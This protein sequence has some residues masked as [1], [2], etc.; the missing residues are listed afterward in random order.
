[1]RRIV[2]ALT[3]LIA[4]GGVL[5]FAASDSN[6]TTCRVSAQDNPCLAQDATI[7]ALELE[8]LRAQQQITNDQ[9]TITALQVIG[10]APEPAAGNALFTETFDNN[11][12]GWQLPNSVSS[13]IRLSQGKLLFS[14]NDYYIYS[15]VPAL[16]SDSYSVEAEVTPL[17]LSVN[18]YGRLMLV[19]FAVGDFETTYQYILIGRYDQQSDPFVR[20]VLA[21]EQRFADILFETPY[22][23][24]ADAFQDG[25]PLTVRLELRNGL[26]TLYVNGVQTES[27][28]AEYGNQVGLGYYADQDDNGTSAAFDNVTVYQ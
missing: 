24:L 20:V 16:D 23:D 14:S 18:G 8:L 4:A 6:S 15:Q 11:D 9:A 10:S 21:T 19:G 25:V 12:R 1:M 2:L 26:V 28:P 27:I 22:P 13:A 3:L 5:F 17:V 7:T